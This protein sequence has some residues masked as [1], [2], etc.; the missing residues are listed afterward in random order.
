[1]EISRSVA[2]SLQLITR[3]PEKDAV[4]DGM[5]GLA[6]HHGEQ[7]LNDGKEVLLGDGESHGRSL[8]RMVF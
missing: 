5:G 1:M 8:L 4:Q 3:K 7:L 6:G 2:V